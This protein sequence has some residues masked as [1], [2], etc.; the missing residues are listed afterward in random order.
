MKS[1][2]SAYSNFYFVGNDQ[3]SNYL[4][5]KLQNE[6]SDE[7]IK[8]LKSVANLRIN[9]DCTEYAKDLTIKHKNKELKINLGHEKD[10]H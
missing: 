1:Q 5:D 8:N 6:S 2:N 7:E 9:D 3:C 4:V 10:K